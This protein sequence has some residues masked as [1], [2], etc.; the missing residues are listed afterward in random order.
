MKIL[1]LCHNLTGR[2]VKQCMIEQE[3]G[4]RTTVVYKECGIKK[5]AMKHLNR[6]FVCGNLQAINSMI[7]ETD[8][9]VAHTSC[10]TYAQIQG[11]N[12]FNKPLVWNIHDWVPE[13]EQYLDIVDAVIVP[14]IGYTKFIPEGKTCAVIYGKVPSKLWPKWSHHRITATC[15]N[16]VVGDSPVFRNYKDANDMLHGNL[17]V[18]SALLP[19]KMADRM[20]VMETSEYE[21]MLEKMARF[22][23]GWPG[24]GSR[25][26]NFDIVV[27]NKFWEMIAAGCVPI[28]WEAQEMLDIAEGFGIGTGMFNLFPIPPQNTIDDCR[29]NIRIN[30]Q[31]LIGESEIPKLNELYD[32]VMEKYHASDRTT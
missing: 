1:H 23:T 14:S 24:S 18:L 3:A 17:V 5:V 4:H 21:P 29:E 27:N 26:V 9:I 12:Q 30:K 8:I 20:M 28:V 2:T 15:M 7:S 13:C 22:Q 6:M 31:A 16:G 25:D 10:R 11:M 19:S 32:Y